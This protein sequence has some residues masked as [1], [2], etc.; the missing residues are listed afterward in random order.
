VNR[1]LLQACIS[2]AISP[3]ISYPDQ[4]QRFA[5]HGL[6]RVFWFSISQKVSLVDFLLVSACP[7]E[8]VILWVGLF[9]FTTGIRNQRGCPAL[10]KTKYY[11]PELE[12]QPGTPS[13]RPSTLST[14]LILHPSSLQMWIYHDTAVRNMFSNCWIWSTSVS[15][16]CQLK[17]LP[18]FL[19]SD[20]T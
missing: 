14:K 20:S 6:Y 4:S 16:V 8:K 2:S 15:G 10:Q 3:P 11:L 9:L 19:S 12:I 18:F 13:P 7:I 1:D 17:Y 5:K